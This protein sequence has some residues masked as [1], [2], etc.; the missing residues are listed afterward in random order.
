MRAI[1]VREIGISPASE[2]LQ[3]LID[4]AAEEQGVSAFALRLQALLHLPRFA[5]HAGRVEPEDTQHELTELAQ[6]IRE[7]QR[8]AAELAHAPSEP[9]NSPRGLRVA[10]DPDVC[11]QIF[12]HYHYLASFRSGSANLAALSP[13]GQP[14]AA[15]SLSPLDLANV[16]GSLPA[17]LTAPDVRV[18]S[19]VYAFEW[20]PAN[21]ISWM[22]SGAARAA[23]AGGARMLLTYVNPNM[24]FGGASYRAANWSLFAREHGTRYAYLDRRYITDRALIASHGTSQPDAL[25]AQLG[26]RIS[27]STMPLEPLGLYALGLDTPTRTELTTWKPRELLRPTP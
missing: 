5:D 13:S 15:V 6:L 19:R 18:V 27:H 4:N 1:A 25:R 16:E 23:R 22:L 24:G 10:E 3:A 2:E 17:D 9:V 8:F 7:R 11:Y 20:A 14:A 21:T 12:S 26:D